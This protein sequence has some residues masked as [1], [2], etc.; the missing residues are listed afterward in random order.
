MFVHL[1]VHSE[2][3]L[4]DGSCRIKELVKRAKELDMDSIAITDHGVMYGAI[5]FYKEAKSQGIKPII[6]CEIYVA[7]RSLYDKEYGIDNLN[8]H[9]ILLC[10]NMTG[11]ENL[12]KIVSKASIDGFYYKPRVDHE[13]LK[14]HSEGLIAL[15]SCLGGEI[16]SY[17][18]SDDYEKAK[19]TAIL[20]NSIF[21]KGNFYLE[22]QY[23]GL[24][25]QE[26]VNSELIKLSKEL[27][28]PIVATNDVHYLD[29]DDHMAHE[30]LLCI[31]TGKN[32]DDADRM[33][34]P[35]DEFYL[36][37]SD[38]MY[39]MFSY[40]REALENTEKI[41]EMCNLEFEFNKTKLPKYD[42]P[43][44][45]TSAEY[46]R[47][48]C[49]EGL[50][51]RYANPSKEVIERLNYELSVIEKMGYVDYFLIV[52]DFIK[53]AR[54]N[55]I[56]TGPGRGSAAGSLVAYCLGITK[57][58][59][60][61]YNLLFERFLNPE[62]V[63]MPDID[64]DFCY[65][66][67]QEVIDYVVKKYG[68]DKVAQIITFGTMA[69]RAAIRDVGRALN[70]PYAEVDAIAKMI[71]FEPGMTID[72]AIG[73]NPELKEKYENDEKIRQLIEISRSLEGLPRHASTHAAGVVISSEPLVKYV[74]LQKNEGSIVTQ[75]T[76]TT[77]EELGLLK[78]DFLGLRTLTVIR[79]TLNI[80][81]ETRSI[82]VDIDN[83]DFEDKEVYA[84]I[85]KGDTEGVFQLE[86]SGMKQ[87]MTELKPEK[88]EDIIAGISLY[89][90]GPMDQIPRYIENKNHPENIKYEHPLLKPILDVT[91]GC[92]VY[93]EQ[94]MQIVRDLAGYSL[95][96]SDLVRR[97]MAKK[98]MKV[99]EE[100]RKNFIYGIKDESGNY[101]VPGAINKGV[102][103]AT[104]NRLFDEMIDFANYAFNKSHAA[105]YAV[106]AFQTAYLKR[107][108][109]V[110]FMAALLNSFVDNTDKV[111]FYVQVLKKMGIQVLPPDI[112]ESY[113]HFSVVN[114]KI[115]FGLAAVKNVGL[116][117][118]LEIVE[119][120]K[121]NGR[122]ISIVDFFERIDDM[123]LNKKAVES[124]IKAGA[125]DS[126]G[127]YR[128]QLLAVYEDIMDSIHKNR[129]RNIKGQMSLFGSEI[130]RNEVN[131][132][133]PDIKEFSQDMILSMEKET[134]GLYIS[135]HPLDEF[136]ED[137]QRV[138][139]CTTRDLKNGDDTFVK[140]S[141]FD[142][143]D[144][145]L[146]GIIES[147]KIKF[148]KNNNMMAF[149]NLEDLY[150]TIEVIVFPTIYERYSKF[151]REDLPVIIKGKVSLKEEEEPK[152]LCDEIEPLTHKVREKLWLNVKEQKDIE[153]IKGVLSRYRGNIPVFIKYTNK[154]LAAKKD[155]WVNGTNEL[156]DEL[157]SILGKENVKIV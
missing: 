64:S 118:T 39:E 35:T 123:Q 86:S 139:N 65:E 32:M 17:L 157:V 43:N 68:E 3:S 4:L 113:S 144:V 88:L 55:G 103:E 121:K 12:M 33:S 104:A 119:D 152:I 72:K 58:D 75:F 30:V 66:R 24:S 15:S 22:L 138:A 112:N 131:Y 91:Y 73:L 41:A 63:S 109:P 77:L 51:K 70:F 80:I 28:I 2:Y 57:I 5:E 27:D 44:G 29:R 49:I 137:I 26:K 105:A 69:A 134:M 145:V 115:R 47:K 11:Y 19:D 60:I 102:D 74:P 94:V 151:L 45:M 7:P 99:M 37:S 153:K 127:V 140:K 132:S 92:M 149:V 107:Y 116:N 21:G 54:D 83:I 52:W 18:L 122:Y 53:F 155:L 89:R 84:L 154:S 128:S 110:E 147:K 56:M 106:V 25:E 71:P 6:G 62:R 136:Q 141:I 59:P 129:E 20:Y 50:N 40:C 78:M 10:K 48:L 36:K 130:E 95:G 42:V 146:A 87:F 1:H 100:E 111:A 67:R 101:V 133:L 120:R 108:Y 85:S 61:K 114:G 150:G 156:L 135:G 143:Q 126:F 14:N 81:K 117:A 34:F 97:A 13:Y 46:L 23:H 8:Y 38:E 16:P 98:K 93:Q 9:L 148:T 82:D 125:F 90:P 76:M 31:Q 79:D 96:R 124:L 142:N